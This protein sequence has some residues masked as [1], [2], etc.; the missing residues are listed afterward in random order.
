VGEGETRSEVTQ[1]L[2]SG[3]G[4]KAIYIHAFDMLVKKI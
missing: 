1:F 2:D 4:P 3:R